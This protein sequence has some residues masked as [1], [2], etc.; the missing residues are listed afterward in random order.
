MPA[1][2]KFKKQSRAEIDA[3]R[4]KLAAGRRNLCT[5]L[6]FWKACGQK[7]CLRAQACVVDERAC[8]DRLWPIVPE[9]IKICIRTISKARQARLSDAEAKAETVRELTRWDEMIARQNAPQTAAYATVE[10][11]SQAQPV[12]SAAS[13][14]RL[15]VL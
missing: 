3:Y 9:R 8:F 5:N 12:A 4:E 1:R 7:K 13:G 6:M 2:R 14:P 10:P 15:R 11:A